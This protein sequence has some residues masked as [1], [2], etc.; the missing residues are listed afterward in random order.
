M[1]SV[2]VDIMKYDTCSM[3]PKFLEFKYAPKF[4]SALSNQTFK[5]ILYAYVYEK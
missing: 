5:G 4:L 2:I 1:T 3:S